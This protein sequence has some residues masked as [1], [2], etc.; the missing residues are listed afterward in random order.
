MSGAKVKAKRLLHKLADAFDS[1]TQDGPPSLPPK[2][3]SKPLGY[4]P[5][6]TRPKTEGH[7]LIQSFD[8]LALSNT[9]PYHPDPSFIGGFNPLYAPAS[10]QQSHSS[11]SLFPVLPKPTSLPRPPAMPK[12]YEHA[13]GT[14]SLTMQIALHPE[15][16]PFTSHR[17]RPLRPFSTPV[18][19]SS[20]IYPSAPTSSSTK[21][22]QTSA[23]PPKP[24]RPRASSTST[25]SNSTAASQQCAGV[26]KAGKRCARQVKSGPPLSQYTI[27]DHGEITSSAIER[28]CF[29]HTKE[30]LGPSGYY[31]RKD[32]EW[33]TFGD[34]IPPYLQPE[35]RVAL[36]IEMEKSRSQSDIAGYIY[37]FEIRGMCNVPRSHL[38]SIALFPTTDSEAL[39][40]IKLKVGRAVNLVKRIDQWGK[41]CGSKEQ[42][43]RGWYPGTV[44]P[45][46]SLMKGR[47]KAG[48]KG[49]W[50]HRMERLI[51]LELADLAATSV[52]LHP[53]WPRVY[54]ADVM[55]SVP[56]NAPSNAPCS[57]CGSLHRE[58]FEFRRLNGRSKGKEWETVVQPVIERWGTFVDRFV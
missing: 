47:I 48:D 13:S 16:E 34:W 31:A 56:S 14:P 11:P 2:P 52:Y 33:V 8:A 19:P 28:F 3:P 27:E 39:D 49:P 43:L 44:E 45:D 46:G 36:R 5:S 23:T 20:S 50:C 24:K 18:L 6:A 35:T 54:T 51:H 37:T 57:D 12:P 9:Q 53:A 38:C 25:S 58:I 15:G 41:Q 40:T 21:P 10:H 4:I 22:S 26:T 42:V 7:D 1:D 30:L 29:Q 17:P 55:T 32:G